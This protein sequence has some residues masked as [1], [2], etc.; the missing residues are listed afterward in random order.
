MSDSQASTVR[1]YYVEHRN[2]EYYNLML[3]I[4]GDF[5]HTVVQTG[6]EVSDLI[7]IR[8]AINDFLKQEEKG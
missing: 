5:R 7:K 3:Q 1:R 6:V 2:A 8:D 4:K